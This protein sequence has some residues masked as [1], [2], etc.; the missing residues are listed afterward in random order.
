MLLLLHPPQHGELAGVY[1]PANGT[2]VGDGPLAPPPPE[3]NL[4]GVS[5]TFGSCR[6]VGNP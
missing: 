5:S 2:P 1:H 4:T 3:V 6:T